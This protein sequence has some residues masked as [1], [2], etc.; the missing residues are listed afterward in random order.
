M[1]GVQKVS[2]GVVAGSDRSATIC[3]QCVWLPAPVSFRVSLPS[4]LLSDG[5]LGCLWEARLSIDVGSHFG[6]KCRDISC[7]VVYFCFC[8]SLIL[9]MCPI[10]ISRSVQSKV[11]LSL[12]AALVPFFIVYDATDPGYLHEQKN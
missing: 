7:H 9:V 6:D 2:G 11:N 1:C 8:I 12:M 10:L 3:R 5:M 4:G